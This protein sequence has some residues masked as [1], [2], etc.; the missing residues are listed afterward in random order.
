VQLKYQLFFRSADNY[1]FPVEVILLPKRHV[2][3]PDR[4]SEGAVTGLFR[5]HLVISIRRIFEFIFLI[6]IEADQAE[7]SPNTDIWYDQA[8]IF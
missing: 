6:F 8:L 1:A 3:C 2:S 7:D 5:S 4:D